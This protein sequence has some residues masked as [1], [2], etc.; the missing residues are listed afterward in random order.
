MAPSPPKVRTTSG[1]YAADALDQLGRGVGEVGELKLAVLVVEQ[2]VVG[3][4]E[5]LARR[6]KLGPAHL[7][8]VLAGGRVAAVGCGL[9]IGEADHGGLDAGF[10]GEHQR[11]SEAEAFVV[12]MGGNAE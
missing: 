1:L 8:E 4:A 7:A 12:G 9:A 2:L 5:D 10:R 6:G 11:A 3:D